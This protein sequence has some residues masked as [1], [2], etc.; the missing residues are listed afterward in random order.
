MERKLFCELGPWAYRI[1]VEKMCL[2]RRWRNAKEH[3]RFA[4][5]RREEKLHVV[6]Y[7][8][9][10]LIR[11][12]LGNV[13]MRLQENKA[14]NLSLAAPKIIGIVIHPGETFSF[15]ELV[16]R[17]SAKK[18]YQEGL[19]IA[20]GRT[21]SG[22]GGGMCQ[23]TNLIHWMVLHSPLTITEHH[24]HD[25]MDLFPD[26]GRQIPFGTRHVYCI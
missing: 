20:K 16:G 4:K 18:G 11:R 2:L 7:R 1:S 19:T 6:I 24:H 5:N 21:K 9:N 15:W 25:Q 8:H 23:M 26:F 22:I 17:T 3:V 13:D 14:V 10:S 12:R